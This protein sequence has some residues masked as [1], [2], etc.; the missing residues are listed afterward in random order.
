MANEI[1]EALVVYMKPERELYFLDLFFGTSV[2]PDPEVPWETWSDETEV[3]PALF[4]FLPS[5]FY[6]I[7]AFC[8]RF[9]K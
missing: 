9:E 1:P 3:D 8:L 2:G 5:V 4:E 6:K 7:R